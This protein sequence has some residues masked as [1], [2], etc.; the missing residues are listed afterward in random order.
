MNRQTQLEN[1]IK[2]IEKKEK[3]ETQKKLT[4]LR[5]ICEIRENYLNE[6]IKKNQTKS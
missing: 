5:E 3:T 6:I 4:K 2:F 1:Q